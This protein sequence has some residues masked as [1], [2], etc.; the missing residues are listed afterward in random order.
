MM[1]NASLLYYKSACAL[2]LPTI[3]VPQVVGF[4]VK[5]GQKHYYF[6]GASTPFNL[7]ASTRMAGDKY[8]MNKILDSA[9]FPVPLARTFSKATFEQEPIQTL[10]NGLTFP[11]VVKPTAGTF[12]GKDV[13]CNIQTIPQLHAYMNRCYQHHAYLTVEAFHSGLRSY[14]VLV[15]FN[16]VIAITERLP[17]SVTGDG[18]H[19]I[20][21][22]IHLENEKRRP[23]YHTGEMG[24]IV[25]D[26][27]C[28]IRLD[29]LNVTL[30]TI[31][32]D[33]ENITLNYT[34][35]SGRGGT[36]RALENKLCKE[37]ARLFAKAA[38]TLGLNLVGF[39]VQCENIHLPI[40][41]SRGVI[42]EANHNPDIIMH[43]N[44]MSGVR[45]QISKKIVRKLIIQHPIHYFIALYH[46]KSSSFYIKSFFI[47]IAFLVCKS[48][49]TS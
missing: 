30:D 12:D 6:Q 46:T 8:S 33:K 21:E 22:L 19:T 4:S 38:A 40:E 14:R 18:I 45:A 1:D 47:S 41:Q 42:I 15:F 27:E 48:L 2:K 43:E 9:G 36:E 32:K 37:N 5:L 29:E 13:L 16:K 28:A 17:A 34:S 20:Q 25:M 11:L 23:Y 24:P 7:C 3:V 39:D 49:V 44:P 10:I 31:L 26:E 35:N